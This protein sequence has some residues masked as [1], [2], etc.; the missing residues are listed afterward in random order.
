MTEGYAKTLLYLI[1]DLKSP[2]PAVALCI[3]TADELSIAASIDFSEKKQVVDALERSHVLSRT[4]K[5]Y[6]DGIYYNVSRQFFSR[7]RPNYRDRLFVNSESDKSGGFCIIKT[8]AKTPSYRQLCE[9]NKCRFYL[10]SENR[11]LMGKRFGD[12]RF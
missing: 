11:C 10:G 9:G 4:T 6:G 1:E 2:Y 7:F 3:F 12:Y 5:Y 8:S